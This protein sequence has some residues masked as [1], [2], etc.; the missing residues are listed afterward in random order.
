LS[1]NQNK[2]AFKTAHCLKYVIY[3]EMT[4]LKFSLTS[5]C[6]KTT[7]LHIILNMIWYLRKKKAIWP[8][9]IQQPANAGSRRIKAW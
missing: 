4:D 6:H 1:T 7:I 9:I 8:G 3:I 5:Q 2:T